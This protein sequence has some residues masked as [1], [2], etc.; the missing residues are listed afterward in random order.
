MEVQGRFSLSDDA[1]YH[2]SCGSIAGV[3]RPDPDCELCDGLGKIQLVFS[4]VDCDCVFELA[5][6]RDDSAIPHEVTDD[7]ITEEILPADDDDLDIFDIFYGYG[8][9]GDLD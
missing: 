8:G 9:G 6:L 4:V 2:E 7:A 5:I 1:T 3:K